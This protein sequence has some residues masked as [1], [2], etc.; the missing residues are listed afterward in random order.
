[1]RRG[2][3]GLPITVQMALNIN[4]FCAYIFL[5]LSKRGDLIMVLWRPTKKPVHNNFL[6]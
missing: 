4:P 2:F 6:K 3:D 5:F 1:M